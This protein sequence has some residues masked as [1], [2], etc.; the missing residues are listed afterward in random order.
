MKKFI[1]IAAVIF[2]VNIAP[3]V[4][5]NQIIPGG[6]LEAMAIAEVERLL[7]EGGETRRREISLLRPLADFSV[8]N[9]VIDIRV[10]VPSAIIDYNGVTPV[11]AR[12]FIGGR[13]YRDINFVVS[14]KVFD[15]VFVATHDLRIETPVTQADFRMAEIAV[16]GRTE[17]IKDL[18][19]ILG[20]VPH[21]IIRAGTP[22]TVNYFR[23]P[24]AISNNRPV[25]IIVRYKG[26]E[27][28]ARGTALSRGRIGEIIRVRNDAS[29]K[30]ISARVIDEDTVEVV[31]D[32]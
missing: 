17:Y 10:S 12:V 14:V 21:R 24:V 3:R 8:P 4:F 16:D 31:M 30:I 32:Y 5:A 29:Q 27:A 7:D 15:F 6:Q 11:K 18:D 22:V 2:F 28:R 9:G 26:I 25:T 23:Q 20:L 19:E 1:F 13:T